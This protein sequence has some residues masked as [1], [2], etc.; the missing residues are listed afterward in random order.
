MRLFQS[1]AR[2]EELIKT[3]KSLRISF[4]HP[5]PSAIS[6]V[7]HKQRRDFEAIAALDFFER[8][9]GTRRSRSPR[10]KRRCACFFP[11]NAQTLLVPGETLLGR[12]WVT[13]KPL[14]ADRLG[15][16]G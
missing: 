10:P 12:T 3:V 9:A 16:A 14:W 6:R 1:F 11:A 8:G 4:G 13:R 7:M 15:C 2:Y 5:D